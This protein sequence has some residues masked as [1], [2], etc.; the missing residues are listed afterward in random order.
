M[1]LLCSYCTSTKADLLQ[2]TP[3]L[4]QSILSRFNDSDTEVIEFSWNALSAVTKVRMNRRW[5]R[6]IRLERENCLPKNVSHLD[7]LNQFRILRFCS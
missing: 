2:Y 7:S 6:M 1:N 4:L 5:H 3:A